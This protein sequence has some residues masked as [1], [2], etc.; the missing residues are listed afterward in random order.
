MTENDSRTTKVKRKR[1]RTRSQKKSNGIETFHDA[2]VHELSDMQNAEKQ[3]V[4][5]LPKMAKAAFNPELTKAFETHLKETEQQ[6]QL[7]DKAAKSCGMKL[8]NEKCD[9]MEGLINEG[10]EI[11]KD[12]KEGAVRDSMLIAAAQKVEH[13]EIAGY[14]CLVAAATQLGFSEAV[15]FLDQILDQEKRTDEKLNQLA[16]QGINQDASQQNYNSQKGKETMASRN[17]KGDQYHDCLAL[18]LIWR[19]FMKYSYSLFRF[20]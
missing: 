18:L 19:D 17:G 1:A 3:L 15:K 10:K 13:Y 5:A 20:K 6:V 12:V 11:I 16:E 4:K 2:F 7:I 8:K 9:A 14:G